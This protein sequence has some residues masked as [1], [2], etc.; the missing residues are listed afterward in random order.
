MVDEKRAIFMFKDGSLAWD[1]KEFLID[2]E[3][4]EDCT[5]ENQPFYGKNSKNKVLLI[6]V[7]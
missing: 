6:K 3:E 7:F 1:A 5:L 2:Q 4:L